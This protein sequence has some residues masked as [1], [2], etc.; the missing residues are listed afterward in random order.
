MRL[1]GPS[2]N[3]LLLMIGSD[4]FYNPQAQLLSSKYFAGASSRL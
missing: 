2:Q 1:R 4:N 3:Q